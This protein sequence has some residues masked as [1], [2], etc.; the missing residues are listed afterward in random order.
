MRYETQALLL[1]LLRE[2]ARH[3]AAASLCLKLTRELDAARIIT[4]AAIAAVSDAVMRK[5]ASDTPSVLAEHYGGHAGGPSAPFGV[6]T[7]PFS[8][9]TETLK[10]VDP[11]LAVCRAQL[12]AYFGSV[13]RLIPPSHRLFAWE[14][15]AQFAE[16]ELRLVEQVRAH[17]T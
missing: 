15:S 13:S 16:A 1:R 3:Y 17:V 7:L 14:A 10:V 4:F 2:L 12:L 9:E 8:S 6:E 5:R 11:E